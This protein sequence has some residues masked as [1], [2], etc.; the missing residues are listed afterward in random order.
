LVVA[1][2]TIRSCRHYEKHKNKNHYQ[3]HIKPHCIIF[4]GCRSNVV[5][6]R[7]AYLQPSRSSRG[8][9]PASLSYR[10]STFT[11]LAQ[12]KLVIFNVWPWYGKNV[13]LA[14]PR[15]SHRLNSQPHLVGTR[16]QI[17]KGLSMNKH[18]LIRKSSYPGR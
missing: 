14:V 17:G 15:S 2:H 9:N 10:F 13:S 4:S 12:S 11:N 5:N 7:G 8:A 18:T 16:L 3:L 6:S 1:V